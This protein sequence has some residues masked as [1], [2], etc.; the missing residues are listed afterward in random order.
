ML[1]SL[2]N[3]HSTGTDR[4]NAAV[5]VTSAARRPG[6]CQAVPRTRRPQPQALARGVR[7]PVDPRACALRVPYAAA[8]M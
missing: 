6:P 2:L 7:P 3:S 5:S 4:S 1:L 8:S